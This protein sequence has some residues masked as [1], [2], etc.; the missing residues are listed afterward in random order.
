[1]SP[2]MKLFERVIEQR[3]RSYLEDIPGVPKKV[4]RL[5]D[6]RTKDVCLIIKILSDFSGKHFNLDFDTKFAQ[7]R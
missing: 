4:T 7:I 5:M 1:M 3:L 6:H 2:I